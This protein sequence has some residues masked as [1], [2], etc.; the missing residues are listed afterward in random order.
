LGY[1]SG[2]TNRKNSPRLV[3]KKEP[4][5]VTKCPFLGTKKKAPGG[6]KKCLLGSQ[7]ENGK[8]KT[9]WG[10]KVPWATGGRVFRTFDLEIKGKERAKE[11]NPGRKSAREGN[12]GNLPSEGAS[13]TLA[14]GKALV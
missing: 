1:P 9:I 7:K 13:K 8:R 11:R 5:S 3:E 6:G 14:L 12:T 2:P 10:A 4:K